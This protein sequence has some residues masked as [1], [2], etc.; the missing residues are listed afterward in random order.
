MLTCLVLNTHHTQTNIHTHSMN[1]NSSAAMS[2]CAD[3]DEGHLPHQ[4]DQSD[5]K[6]PSMKNQTGIFNHDPLLFIAACN[7]CSVPLQH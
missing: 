5:C 1:M 3:Y 7:L 2:S 4:H 6:S